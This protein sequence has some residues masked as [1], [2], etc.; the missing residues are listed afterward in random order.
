ML[1]DLDT[2]FVV[3]VDLRG[4]RMWLGDDALYRRAARSAL[5][6]RH[7]AASPR[8]RN[9][10]P[11]PIA[12][13]YEG[14]DDSDD[15]DPAGAYSVSVRLESTDVSARAKVVAILARLARTREEDRDEE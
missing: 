7:M 9:R 8:P 14:G 10:R 12:H 6:S 13:D 15:A 5:T 11:P 4:A 3:H 2:E 1:S